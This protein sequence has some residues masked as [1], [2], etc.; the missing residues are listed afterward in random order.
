MIKQSPIIKTVDGN[1]SNRFNLA[2]LT[3]VTL[4][5]SLIKAHLGERLGPSSMVRFSL[6]CHLLH[7]TDNINR[8]LHIFQKIFL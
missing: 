5:V 1:T 2:L 4:Q 3:I 6:S 7:I 8:K